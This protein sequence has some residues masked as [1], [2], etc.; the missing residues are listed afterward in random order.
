MPWKISTRSNLKIRRFD[1]I[2]DINMG[3]IGQTVQDI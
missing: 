1:A 2:I 3:D